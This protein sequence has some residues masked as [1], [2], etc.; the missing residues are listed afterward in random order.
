MDKQLI[1][2]NVND[3][4]KY[5]VPINVTSC[6]LN[7]IELMDGKMHISEKYHINVDNGSFNYIIANKS[8]RKQN[9]TSLITKRVTSGN[10]DFQENDSIIY[11]ALNR[12]AYSGSTMIVKKEII[13][14]LIP[15]LSLNF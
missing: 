8:E 12:I 2:K 15:T 9:L 6:N 11:N 14:N 5:K 3:K 13:F 4:K 7:I 10:N 1:V